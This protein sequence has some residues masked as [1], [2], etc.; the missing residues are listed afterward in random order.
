[1][2]TDVR[3]LTRALG[4][5]IVVSLGIGGAAFADLTA[6]VQ[7][8]DGAY[9]WKAE[10]E[11]SMPHGKV[12]DL[13]LTS[14]VWQGITWKHRLQIAVPSESM[15]GDTVLLFLTGGNNEE[16]LKPS[17][18][19]MGFALAQACGAPCAMLYQVPNQPLLGDKREDAL[20][21]ETFVRYLETGDDTWPLLFP[22]V[23]SAVR[24]MDAVQE[25]ARQNGQPAVRRF[26]VAG[27]SKRG[28]TTWLTAA[29][30]PRVAAIAPMVIDTLNMKA[31]KSHALEVW[32][33]LSEQ[34]DDY[35]RRGLTE[36]Y[37][38]E[39][40]SRLWL[41]VDPYSYRDRLLLPK[42]LIFG[43]N[44]PYWTLDALNVYWDDLKGPKA[45]VYLPNAGHGME[46]NRG[47]A[48]SGLGA[49][50]RHIVAERPMPKLA[51]TH[52]DAAGGRLRLEITS[53]PPPKSA[54]LWVA[55]AP[56]RDFRQAHWNSTPLPVEEGAIV[57]EVAMP[58]K[59]YIALLGDLEYQ[60]DTIRYHLSTQV[61][62]AGA[63][64]GT[65][66]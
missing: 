28:W 20:I 35:T 55:T 47:Y 15:P 39:R 23:K 40:G 3:L 19:A 61:R 65:G 27:A 49:L 26:V 46:Q 62:Q 66:K 42:L 43:T 10:G 25:W 52:S 54:L 13:I 17:D 63:R 7:R 11:R 4:L 22:M 16:V 33:H 14:Q 58:E 53:S 41:M 12:H 5:A 59:G 6:Y 64:A 9:G 38:T 30:D 56:T 50:F 29:V 18:P 1:M 36:Q 24:A 8:G 31:Q 60:I 2:I 34:I 48:V 32:G 45:V 51:W 44:D 21:A 37:D 57:G